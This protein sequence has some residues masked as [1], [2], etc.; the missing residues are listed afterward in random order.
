ML[1]PYSKL[2]GQG[3][4]ADF[5]HTGEMKALICGTATETVLPDSPGERP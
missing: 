5:Q 4:L 3:L 2:R 1:F